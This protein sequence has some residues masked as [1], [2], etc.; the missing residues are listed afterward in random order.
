MKITSSAFVQSTTS[1]KEAPR[2]KPAFALIGRSNVGKSSLLN[3][4][5]SRKN[6]ARTS[7]TPGKTQ[8]INYFLVN[9]QWYLVDLP[10]YGFAKVSKKSRASWEKMVHT[11]L[12]E[13]TL[14]TVFLLLD[15]RH[16]LQAL[17]TA[18]IDFLVQAKRPY[19][20]ILTKADKCKRHQIAT[21]IQKL[22]K[23]LVDKQYALPPLFVT[24]ASKGSGHQDLLQ[25][26]DELL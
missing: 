16:P 2:D 1:F 10:G 6:L 5:L 14:Q 4:L 9:E 24:S 19:A 26:I 12:R 18:F 17:D 20:L 7:T 22:E 25:Y 11:Y 21:H 15:A 3:R 8:L 13:A 23:M